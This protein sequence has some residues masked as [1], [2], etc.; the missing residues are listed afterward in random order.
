MYRSIQQEHKSSNSVCSC[1]IQFNSAIFSFRT[2]RTRSYLFVLDRLSD[3]FIFIFCPLRENLFASRK[4]LTANEIFNRKMDKTKLGFFSFSF[5]DGRKIAVTSL[6]CVRFSLSC[7][8]LEEKIRNEK[9]L[10][11][12]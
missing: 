2:L 12:D 8:F 11:I 10:L 6:V 4:T 9:N 7:L 3:K 5:I 1:E